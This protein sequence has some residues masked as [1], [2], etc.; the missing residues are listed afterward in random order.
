MKDQNRPFRSSS[1]AQMTFM[2]QHFSSHLIHIPFYSNI[3]VFAPR[4][5]APSFSL[6]SSLIATPLRCSPP[7]V[8]TN[9]IT[10]TQQIT[11]LF[12]FTLHFI[13]RGEYDSVWQMLWVGDMFPTC[14]TVIS[15]RPLLSP[16][17]SPAV[18][19]RSH[20]DWKERLIRNKPELTSCGWRF[21]FFT[22]NSCVATCCV[23]VSRDSWKYLFTLELWK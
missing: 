22:S 2:F 9:K 20:N 19:Q 15:E 1:A 13:S 16:Q 8:N 6:S 7:C 4:P 12:C 3:I 21:F 23:H 11:L 10:T 18:L 17:N 14:F 5:L